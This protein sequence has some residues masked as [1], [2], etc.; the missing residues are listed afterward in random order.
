M[1]LAWMMLL[2]F[3]GVGLL[4]LGPMAVLVVIVRRFFGEGSDWSKL[5]RSYPAHS[6]PPR[7]DFI[8]QTLAVGPV[9]YGNRANVGITAQGLYLER[10]GMIRLPPLL[11]PWDAISG[12]REAASPWRRRMLLS[13]GQPQITTLWLP[14]QVFARIEPYLRSR[15]AGSDLHAPAH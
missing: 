3:L 11:I 5:G 10:P 12:V 6:P 4:L 7:L 2:I 14:V 8:R 15:P 9:Y 1:S 13:I